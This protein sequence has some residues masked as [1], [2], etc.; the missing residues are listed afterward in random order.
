MNKIDDS[1]ITGHDRADIII[2]NRSDISSTSAPIF[3]S[4][5]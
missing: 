1:R 5:D 3:I 4:K 2:D